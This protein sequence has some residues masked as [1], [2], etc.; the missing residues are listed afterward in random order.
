MLGPCVQTWWQ[1]NPDR[2][3]TLPSWNV[4]Q[5]ES[6]FGVGCLVGDKILAGSLAKSSWVSRHIQNVV[7]DLECQANVHGECRQAFDLLFIGTTTDTTSN[8]TELKQGS[9]LVLMDPLHSNHVINSLLRSIHAQVFMD[10]DIRTD[11]RC[12]ARVS[13]RCLVLLDRDA[14][15]F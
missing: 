1:K 12:N 5:G 13:S 15:C 6:H 4:V 8:H 11:C 10:K 14:L 7:N 2:N 3:A 9:S